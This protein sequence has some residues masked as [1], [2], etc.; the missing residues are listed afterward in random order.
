M[1]CSDNYLFYLFHF[2]QYTSDVL[3][4]V[5][6]LVLLVWDTFCSSVLTLSGSE[7]YKDG[8]V[9]EWDGG[10]LQIGLDVV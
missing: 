9:L 1:W 4:T 5:L 10:K 7:L 6:C 8:L 3:C 2:H